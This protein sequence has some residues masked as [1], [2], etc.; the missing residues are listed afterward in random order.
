MSGSV[1]L[2]ISGEL[3]LEG[4]TL[5]FRSPALDGPRYWPIESITALYI[6][7][8]ITL[9]KPLLRALAERGIPVHLLTERGKY[10]GTFY[11][12]YMG[13]SAVLLAQARAVTDPETRLRYARQITAG[14]IRQML[15]LVSYHVRRGALERRYGD[16]LEEYMDRAAEAD[17]LESLRSAEGTARRIY[18]DAYG[19]LV[20]ARGWKFSKRVKYPPGDPV[21]AMLSFGYA[22]LY[23][24]ML[25]GIITR[26]NLDPR[27]SFV[28]EMRTDNLPLRL[29]LAD[30][31]KPVLVDRFV[32][33]LLGRGEMGEGDFEPVGG[34]FFLSDAGRR[35]FIRK[36]EQSLDAKLTARGTRRTLRTF[37]LTEPAALQTAIL[38]GED[39]RPFYYRW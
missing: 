11:P 15:G 12:A 39:Y 18:Y 8:N 31:F 1:Y 25:T 21:N 16:M 28:H 14:G 5:A 20:E 9:T 32:L 33:R 35:A 2:T 38:S 36:W 26:S 4:G 7:G 24:L 19:E 34:G 17:S 27:L 13:N 30:I 22:L 29:D 6:F 37:A 10:I 23:S 3:K